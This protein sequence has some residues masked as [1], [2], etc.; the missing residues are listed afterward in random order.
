MNPYSFNEKMLRGRRMDDVK[1]LETHW[2][3]LEAI[4][5]SAA[6]TSDGVS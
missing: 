6:L 1:T 5:F 2:L 3:V 4:L